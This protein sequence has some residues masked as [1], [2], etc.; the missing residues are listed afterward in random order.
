MIYKTTRDIVIPAGSVLHQAARKTERAVPF[1]SFIQ[2]NGRD[3]TIE[4][5]F[6]LDDGL[7][8]GLVVEEDLLKSCFPIEEGDKCV[9]GGT[10]QYVKNGE[11]SCHLKPP[12]AACAESYLQCDKC[13]ILPEEVQ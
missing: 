4:V 10:F 11:C 6:P 12:C 7:L 8:T 5:T 9:C 1:L 3:S 13:S 2:E